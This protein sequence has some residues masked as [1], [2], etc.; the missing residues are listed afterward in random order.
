MPKIH[1]GNL[2]GKGLRVGI[3]QSKFNHFITDRLLDG[4]IEGLTKCGV[5]DSAIQVYRVPG[6]FEIPV[7]MKK[8]ASGGNFDVL[9][10]IGAIIRGE[11]P[12]YDYLSAE[13]T[14]G[15]AYVALEAGIP[16]INGILTTDDVAQAIDRAG[17]KEGNK[18]YDAALNAVEVGALFK[19]KK[20]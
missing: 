18:G 20:L 11:T 19:T 6:S 12:H 2:S 16:V 4:A 17:V 1:E 13:V 15:I 5:D 3:I 9:I 7:I 8:L 14:K 10:A